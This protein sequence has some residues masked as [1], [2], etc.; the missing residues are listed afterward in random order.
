MFQEDSKNNDLLRL[1]VQEGLQRQEF[2]QLNKISSIKNIPQHIQE[3]F[4]LL[5]YV[6][7]F[8]DI[9]QANPDAQEGKKRQANILNTLNTRINPDE[10][11]I[12]KVLQ[13]AHNNNIKN[14]WAVR[15]I[16]INLITAQG[17]FAGNSIYPEEIRDKLS[18]TDP[19]TLVREINR[20]IELKE[21]WFTKDVITRSRTSKYTLNIRAHKELSIKEIL[22]GNDIQIANLKIQNFKDVFNT[23]GSDLGISHTLGDIGIFVISRLL[24]EEIENKL[25][26]LGVK[27]L[28]ANNG[29]EFFISFTNVKNINITE[30]IRNI[31]QDPDKQLQ[32]SVITECKKALKDFLPQNK[33]TAIEQRFDEGFTADKI[34]FYGG[35]STHYNSP[36]EK[37]TNPDDVLDPKTIQEAALTVDRLYKEAFQTAKHEQIQFS[38]K[39]AAIRKQAIAK[40]NSPDTTERDLVNIFQPVVADAAKVLKSGIMQYSDKAMAEVKQNL[41]LGLVNEYQIFHPQIAPRY[42]SYANMERLS[43]NLQTAI[44][45][46]EDQEVLGELKDRL[47]ETV[48][49]YQSNNLLDDYIYEGNENFKRVI[50]Y[51]TSHKPDFPISVTF[52]VGGDE[53]GKIIWNEKDKTLQIYRFDGNNVG[54]TNFEWGMDIGDK[55]ID[56]SLRIISQTDDMSK[57]QEAIDNFFNDMGDRGLVLSDSSLDMLKQKAAN[58]LILSEENYSLLKSN[59]TFKEFTKNNSAVVIEKKDGDFVLIKFPDIH[60][61]YPIQKSEH[62]FD[63]SKL[64]TDETAENAMPISFLSGEEVFDFIMINDKKTGGLILTSKNPRAPPLTKISPEDIANQSPITIA[65]EGKTPITI[66]FKKDFRSNVIVKGN[67]L[68]LNE[69]QFQKIKLSKNKLTSKNDNLAVMV[70]SRPVVNT[71]VVEIDTNKIQPQYLNRDISVIQGRADTA[72][73]HAKE[74]V[75]LNQILHNKVIKKYTIASSDYKFTGTPGEMNSFN[76]FELSF[77][78]MMTAEYILETP[79][80]KLSRRIDYLLN[81]NRKLN[82]NDIFILS[83]LYIESPDNLTY[84]Q[85]NYLLRRMMDTYINSSN[86]EI[87]SLI[88]YTTIKILSSQDRL[89]W[90][91]AVNALFRSFSNKNNAKKIEALFLES[92]SLIANKTTD[93]NLVEKWRQNPPIDA[94]QWYKSLIDR[95]KTDVLSELYNL[96]Y[97]SMI[98]LYKAKN[99]FLPMAAQYSN[100]FASG[101]ILQSKITDE[102]KEF[103]DLI[104]NNQDITDYKKINALFDFAYNKVKQVLAKKTNWINIETDLQDELTRLI[105]GS[106][107]LEDT[108][109]LVYGHSLNLGDVKQ[110]TVKRGQQT[111][112]DNAYIISIELEDGTTFSD[113][114]FNIL[115]TI[116]AIKPNNLKKYFT[117]GALHRFIENAEILNATDA[118]LHPKAGNFYALHTDSR[119]FYR[120]LTT[121]DRPQLTSKHVIAKAQKSFTGSKLSQE[122]ASTIK[123]DII[124]YM[125]AWHVLG[126]NSFFSAPYPNNILAGTEIRSLI[127]MDDNVHPGEILKRFYE[128]YSEYEDWPIIFSS[129]VEFFKNYDPQKQLAGFIF[130]AEAYSYLK[131]QNQPELTQQLELFLKQRIEILKLQMES[132]VNLQNDVFAE[133]LHLHRIFMPQ[134]NRS[135]LLNKALAYLEKKALNDSSFQLTYSVFEEI[136]EKISSL[137]QLHK[138]TRKNLEYDLM[139]IFKNYGYDPQ[140]ELLFLITNLHY[141]NTKDATDQ[142]LAKLIS[143]IEKLEELIGLKAKKD[144]FNFTANALV[145]NI[146][147]YS[148]PAERPSNLLEPLKYKDAKEIFKHYL[149]THT[150]NQT[151]PFIVG[152]SGRPDCDKISL[153]QKLIQK[154]NIIDRNDSAIIDI[155]EFTNPEGV[156]NNDL[157]QSEF[158][159]FKDKKAVFVLGTDILLNQPLQDQINC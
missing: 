146:H 154:N 82:A 98:R 114:K 112:I 86:K 118:S 95:K 32:S 101:E 124:A 80:E 38:S 129:I 19:D 107:I 17:D 14:A 61:P 3:L 55:L 34:N 148:S 91:P 83:K 27:T 153:T 122:I 35:V 63:K 31:I 123:K 81:P 10:R 41:R 30:I 139:G 53:Y 75:K 76:E 37:G 22:S 16:L 97:K 155:S 24:R 57:L 68:T 126:R 20:I 145:F 144:F 105:I 21:Y 60:V 116:N 48:V 39:Y 65:V 130:L 26:P 134:D 125:R 99:N 5:N 6:Q 102:E 52:R 23:F 49:R 18:K 100:L 141:K 11:A 88:T 1:E 59:G 28:V 149:K 46:G 136:I 56:E 135:L 103:H 90:E 78:D 25:A 127:F 84:K 140:E 67:I 151:R 77:F 58:L 113:I 15:D 66:S 8:I 87:T 45:N 89:I 158:D 2:K 47:L 79:E 74:T 157:L 121:V 54:A 51:V 147:P 119:H 43:R 152:I 12:Y 137:E 108:V 117:T 69:K 73:E 109:M 110:L 159:R 106:R 142:S 4:I 138:L 104:I 94:A 44:E 29:G 42:H 96:P 150:D 13:F 70:T 133:I 111:N 93:D 143:N 128:G 7:S 120:I 132:H 64:P 156:I 92:I 71:G 85:K 36:I 50:N 9:R 62:K 115:P 40:K 33:F 131:D 72:A